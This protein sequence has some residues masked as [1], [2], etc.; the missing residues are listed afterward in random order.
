M[1]SEKI[2]RP[3]ETLSSTLAEFLQVTESSPAVVE[4]QERMKDIEASERTAENDAASI[5]VR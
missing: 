1:P 5:R 3:G 4:W 2:E